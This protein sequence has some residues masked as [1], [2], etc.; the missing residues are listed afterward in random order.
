MNLL[1]STVILIFTFVSHSQA[2][3]CTEIRLDDA[4]KC[5]AGATVEDQDG[6]NLCRQYSGAKILD[7]QRFYANGKKKPKFETSPIPLA[8]QFAASSNLSEIEQAANSAKMIDFGAKNGMC[9]HEAIRKR[10]GSSLDKNYCSEVKTVIASITANYTISAAASNVSCNLRKDENNTIKA[11]SLLSKA[12]NVGESVATLQ[13]EMSKICKGADQE[14]LPSMPPVKQLFG[15]TMQTPDA[16]FSAFK[17]VIDSELDAANPMPTQALYCFDFMI[18]GQS[19]SVGIDQATGKHTNALCNKEGLHASVL[20]GRRPGPRGCQYLVHNSHGTS[21]N[22]YDKKW[23][24]KDGKIWVD[25]E[26]LFKNTMGL[27]FVEQGT[28]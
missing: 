5:L 8:I 21:C 16:R 20:I 3:S 27:T 18:A 1:I 9:S 24:C 14:T 25:E 7:C 6:L 13:S 22:Q 11:T 2:S 26:S 15:N 4:D 28:P 17:K 10:F 23:E 19:S 12:L